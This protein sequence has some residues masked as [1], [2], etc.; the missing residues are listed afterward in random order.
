MLF[1]DMTEQSTIGIKLDY[2]AS[3]LEKLVSKQI[4]ADPPSIYRIGDNSSHVRLR[5]QTL[6]ICNGGAATSVNLLVGLFKYNFFVA[7]GTSYVPF[8]VVIDRGV[9]LSFDDA[10]VFGYLIAGVE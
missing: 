7:A 8:P 9:T 6:I 3:L 10:D 1:E 2:V 4:P 5:G